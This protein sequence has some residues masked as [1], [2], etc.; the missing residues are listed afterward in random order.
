MWNSIPDLQLSVLCHVD[1]STSVALEVGGV[2]IAFV[3]NALVIWTA[4]A[5]CN[6]CFVIA[7]FVH[8][9]SMHVWQRNSGGLVSFETPSTCLCS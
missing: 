5:A 9:A 1:W 2:V 6:S 3:S 8:F 7:R 4:K